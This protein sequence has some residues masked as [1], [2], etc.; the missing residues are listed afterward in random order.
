MS[1]SS[2]LTITCT[3][4]YLLPYFVVSLFVPGIIASSRWFNPEG[5]EAR[6]IPSAFWMWAVAYALAVILW[7]LFLVALAFLAAGRVIRGAAMYTWKVASETETCC[8]MGVQSKAGRRQ[9]QKRD[10]EVGTELPGWVVI[11]L[12]SGSSPSTHQAPPPVYSPP[13]HVGGGMTIDHGY[14]AWDS[15]TVRRCS[16]EPRP[17][18]TYPC[19]DK[20]DN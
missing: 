13:S 3:L 17:M 19:M 14:G 10:E 1:A 12:D 20:N 15:F 11:D 8:G 9:E 18:R 2:A 4:V 7:P 6:W 5:Q 16:L